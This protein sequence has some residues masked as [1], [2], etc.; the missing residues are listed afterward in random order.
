MNYQA[1]LLSWH[2][3]YT[4]TG[5]AAASLV[6]L[7]FVGLSLHLRVV[8]TRPDVE[9]LARVTLTS[10][11]VALVASLFI[12]V[13]RGGDSTSVGW[14][15][16]GLGAAAAVLI[17]RSVVAGIRSQYRILSAPRLFLRFGS[18]TLCL[19]GV[20]AVGV[21]LARGDYQ[22]GLAWLAG[23]SIFLVLTSLRNSWDLLV[24]VGAAMHAS[25]TT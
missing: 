24:S 3:F 19:L 15:L 6:G 13:P 11:S 9:G 18:N 25:T 4:I 23:L 7:L 8:V 16:V 22:D 10:F 20:I 12:V 5:T 1:T 2:D 17:V 14:D 21:V